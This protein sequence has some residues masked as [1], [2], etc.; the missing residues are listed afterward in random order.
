MPKKPKINKLSKRRSEY[1]R[2][3][4][5]WQMKQIEQQRQQA[6]LIHEMIDEDLR[7][8]QYKRKD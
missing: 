2:K 5:E 3:Y 1:K 6:W 7:N 8:L 4:K